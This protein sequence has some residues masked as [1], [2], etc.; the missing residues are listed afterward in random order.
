M[1]LQ[2]LSN[3]VIASATLLLSVSL[4]HAQTPAAPTAELLTVKKIWDQG[5]HNAFTDLI[6]FDNLFYCCFREGDIPLGGEGKV[7]VLTSFDG[8]TWASVALVEAA[9]IDLRDPKLGVTKDGRMILFMGGSVFKGSTLESRQPRVCT[10][11]DGRHWSPPEKVLAEGDCLSRATWHEGESKFYG[12][13]YNT[14]PLTSKP[15][16]E[17]EWSE[18]IFTSNDGK[19]WSLNAILAVKG[20]PND[21]TVRLQPNGDML[22]MVNRDAADKTCV[23]GSAKAPYREWSWATPG[24]LCQA[25]NFVV[26]PE[27]KIIA[28]GRSRGATPGAH[29]VLFAMTATTLTPILE[30]PSGGDCSNPGLIFHEGILHVS[31]YS[32][33]EG[34]AAIYYAKVKVN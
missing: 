22:A 19:V 28:A 2:R 24:V 9:G 23:I 30:L 18:K 7:R 10:S 32:S 1:I 33:H 27:G 15:K 20:Q 31:Y 6:R 12:T 25:P 13:V 26:L 3:L 14:S 16:P 5:K 29:T 11:T 21:A 34:K 8:A 4:G 17:P